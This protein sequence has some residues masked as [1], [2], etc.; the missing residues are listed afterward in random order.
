MICTKCRGYVSSDATRCPVCGARTRWVHP[1]MI[2]VVFGG[3]LLA[4]IIAAIFYGAGD[5][6]RWRS[7]QEAPKTR[8]ARLGELTKIEID[9]GGLLLLGATEAG[10][11]RVMQLLRADDKE[12]IAAMFAAGTA[13]GV[14]SGT[15]C[16]VIETGFFTYEVR[17]L[18]GEHSGKSGFIA[19]EWVKEFD[20]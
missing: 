16:R 20:R 14:Q 12:G 4:A 2:N 18:A 19:R 17:I 10:R 8:H 6:L 1:V 9:G 15:D 5:F 3:L 13:F 7:A 11:D